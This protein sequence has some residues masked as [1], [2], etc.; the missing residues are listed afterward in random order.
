MDIGLD[1]G[2]DIVGYREDTMEVLWGYRRGIV[3]I[4][5]GYITKI[6]TF[7]GFRIVKIF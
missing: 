3:G 7:F 5:W 1:I 2:L 4:L 6:E